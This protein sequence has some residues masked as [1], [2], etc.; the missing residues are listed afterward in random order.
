[1][2]KP[3]DWTNVRRCGILFSEVEDGATANLLEPVLQDMLAVV[4]AHGSVV[5][6]VSLTSVALSG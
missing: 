1:M 3:A 2:L 4:E 6:K 5:Q